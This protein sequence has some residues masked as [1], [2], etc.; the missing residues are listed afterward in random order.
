M[1]VKGLIIF[2]V[3]SAMMIIT[4]P[5]LADGAI[6]EP[7]NPGPMPEGQGD[8]EV[9]LGGMVETEVCDVFQTIEVSPPSGWIDGYLA[10]YGLQIGPFCLPSGWTWVDG[11]YSIPAQYEEVCTES[12]TVITFTEA[13]WECAGLPEVPRMQA[14]IDALGN[15]TL[16]GIS[17]ILGE[18]L[19]YCVTQEGETVQMLNADGTE[20]TTLSLGYGISLEAT[21]PPGS[22][23]YVEHPNQNFTEWSVIED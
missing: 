16:T 21:C 15:V 11:Y 4:L 1:K 19:P 10:C 9:M 7:G 22:W 23:A 3:F 20:L 12:H 5:A 8:C 14:K 18:M 13:W 2:A 17:P 6:P